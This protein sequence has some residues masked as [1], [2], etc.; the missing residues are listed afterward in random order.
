MSTTQKIEVSREIRQW[1]GIAL[2]VAGIAVTVYAY[3][4]PN[5]FNEKVNKLKAKFNLH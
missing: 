5:K 3:V 2:S 1:L 4:A